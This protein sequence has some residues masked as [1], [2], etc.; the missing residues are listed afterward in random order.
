[1]KYSAVDLAYTFVPASKVL[2]FSTQPGFDWRALF[3]VI[4]LTQNAIIYAP[5]QTGLG[6]TIDQT[7]LRLTLSY[8]TTTHSATDVLMLYVD[9]AASNLADLLT[10]AKG[11]PTAAASLSA[12]G[13][14]LA[15]RDVGADTYM[16]QLVVE[17]RLIT[18]V[19]AEIGGLTS[20]LNALRATINDEVE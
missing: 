8:D 6:A 13:N 17:A 12:L 7:G 15:V 18:M 5:A 11:M 14:M 16:K 9:D 1:M 19:L 4:N 3:M 2:D 10:L 20:D